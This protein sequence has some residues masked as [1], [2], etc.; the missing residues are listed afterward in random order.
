[1]KNRRFVLQLKRKVQ[2]GKKKLKKKLTSNLNV[3]QVGIV[4]P[5]RLFIEEI[6][7]SYIFHEN[8]TVFEL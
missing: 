4:R 3:F 5:T 2:K 6:N 8:K 7:A 1:M